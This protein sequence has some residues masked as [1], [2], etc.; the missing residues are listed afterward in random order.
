MRL[1]KNFV[2]HWRLN[3]ICHIE[4]DWLLI[5]KIQNDILI[6]TLVDTGSHADL[7]NL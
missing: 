3:D 7:F 4:P 2:R 1:W 5:Y 6:L